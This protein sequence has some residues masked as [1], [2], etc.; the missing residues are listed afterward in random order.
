MSSIYRFKSSNVFSSRN[1]SSSGKFTLIKG[2]VFFSVF[3]SH[4]TLYYLKTKKK[5]KARVSCF[6][7]FHAKQNTNYHNIKHKRL[8]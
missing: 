6:F 3:Y 4:I 1:C 2:L 7:R 8:P 5:K